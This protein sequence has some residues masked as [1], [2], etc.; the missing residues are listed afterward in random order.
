MSYEYLKSLHIIFVVTWFSGLFYL[1]RLFIYHTEA[2]TKPSPEK[3]I[4]TEQFKIM[5][6]RLWYGITWPSSVLVFI[7]GSSLVMDYLPLENHPWLIVKLFFVLFLYLYHLSL[8]KT[9]RNIQQGIFK[10]SSNQLRVYNELATIFLISIVFL[11]VCK[12]VLDMG[13]GIIG[14]IIFSFILMGSIR[15]YKKIRERS[16]T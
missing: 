12:N 11:V 9:L 15:V 16:G 2:Q 14:L 10:L 13:K 5:E 7:F 3:E 4:L 8:G 6:K 1:V